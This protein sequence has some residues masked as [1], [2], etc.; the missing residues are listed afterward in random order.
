[1]GNLL[2]AQSG[3]PT[4]AINATIVGVL[5]MAKLSENIEKVYGAKY[6]IKGVL[7]EDLID[8]DELKRSTKSLELLKQTPCCG[9]GFLPV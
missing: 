8:L 6:G 1:M 7:E 4:A 2:V 3:G 9:A 5:E